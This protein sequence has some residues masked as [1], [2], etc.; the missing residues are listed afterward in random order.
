VYSA[1]QHSTPP[2]YPYYYQGHFDDSRSRRIY[3]RLAEYATRATPDSMKTIQMDNFNQDS[4]RCT[5]SDVAFA[6]PKT[7][8]A[9]GS[10]QMAA[11]LK[12]WDF[13]YEKDLTGPCTF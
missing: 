7:R 9:R 3:N 2:S 1:N 12:S 8:F 5:A 6:R 4:R 10:E 11:E 13:R